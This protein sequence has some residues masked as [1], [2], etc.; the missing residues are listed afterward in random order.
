MGFEECDEFPINSATADDPGAGTCRS[1]W[2]R[3]DF[4]GLNIDET[5]Q[6]LASL[7]VHTCS[8]LQSKNSWPEARQ[9]LTQNRG[10]TVRT[11]PIHPNI[12]H[13]R[14][15]QNS[16]PPKITQSKF[17]EGQ[18]PHYNTTHHGEDGIEAASPARGTLR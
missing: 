3:I 6:G 13:L 12:P 2:Q 9:N 14:H 4:P 11:Y 15:P 17:T 10:G 8:L 1:P 16:N 7:F 18:P 5:H